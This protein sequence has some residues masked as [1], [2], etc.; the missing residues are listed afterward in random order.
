MSSA[1][2]EKYKKPK[3]QLA[4]IMRVMEL[5]ALP[6]LWAS[7]QLNSVA[8]HQWYYHCADQEV[9]EA[10]RWSFCLVSLIKPLSLGLSSRWLDPDSA[11][12]TGIWG[13]MAFHVGVWAPVGLA[14]TFPS[15][16]VLRREATRTE[17]TWEEDPRARSPGNEE[18]EQNTA[19]GGEGQPRRAW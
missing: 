1:A 16:D 12:N 2:K 14:N 4:L 6:A 10:K 9:K 18:N 19:R 7:A 17:E 8:W 13:E 11:T 5:K 15:T 3:Q